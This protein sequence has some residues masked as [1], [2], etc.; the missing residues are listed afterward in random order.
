MKDF[1]E[2]TKAIENIQ[3]LES[4]EEKEFRL[5]ELKYQIRKLEIAVI[6]IG[7]IGLSL[8]ALPILGIIPFNVFSALIIIGGIF[9]ILKAFKDGETLEAEKFFLQIILSNNKKEKDGK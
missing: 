8:I 7:L 5:K 3:S 2:I 1:E 9:L 6:I 4:K